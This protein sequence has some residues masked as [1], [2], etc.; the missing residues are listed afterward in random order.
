[1][2]D[3]DGVRAGVEG[4]GRESW[5]GKGYGGPLLVLSGVPLASDGAFWLATPHGS[6]MPAPVWTQR[7]LL[8]YKKASTGHSEAGDFPSSVYGGCFVL[9]KLSYKWFEVVA[10]PPS[11]S[12][13]SSSSSFSSSSASCSFFLSLSLSFHH[14]YDKNNI[15]NQQQQQ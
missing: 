2:T 1:M 6:V 9:R 10:S 14:R 15:H 11:S 5:G 12:S 3:S 4:M 8:G 13:S 7:L